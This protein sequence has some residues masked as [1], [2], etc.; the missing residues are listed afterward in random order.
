MPRSVVVVRKFA[1]EPEAQVAQ[2]VLEA[3]GIPSVMMCDDA[4]GMIPALRVLFPFRLTVRE[5]DADEAT[6][7]LDADPASIDD[8]GDD[9]ED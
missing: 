5:S 6:R 7:V 8:D 9:E 1:T 3:H 2:L 4:G